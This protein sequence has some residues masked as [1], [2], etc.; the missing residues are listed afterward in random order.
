MARL[1]GE[2]DS[3][4]I[5]NADS[6]W[7]H[8]AQK[9]RSA[10]FRSSNSI[11]S[12]LH[13]PSNDVQMKLLYTICVPNITYACEVATYNHK[14]KESMH[15]AVNDAIRKIYSYNRWE[16]VKELHNRHQTLPQIP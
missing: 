14:D 6:A 16:S 3:L 8:L 4:I 9:P 7:Y 11:L 15:V 5:C 10:F 12:V 13:G 2:S 1:C